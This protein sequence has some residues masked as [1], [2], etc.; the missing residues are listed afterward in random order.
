MLGTYNEVVIEMNNQTSTNDSTDR[1]ESLQQQINPVQQNHNDMNVP[2]SN[3]PILSNIVES[4]PARSPSPFLLCIDENT[5]VPS[6][7]AISSAVTTKTTTLT[8]DSLLAK[9]STTT[10]D[11]I[12][13]QNNLI[14]TDSSITI[15]RSSLSSAE[16]PSLTKTIQNNRAASRILAPSTTIKRM[17]ASSE[18]IKEIKLLQ[19]TVN[20]RDAE[21]KKLKDQNEQLKNELEKMSKC[22][23]SM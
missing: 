7:S 19:S 20:L 14:N 4:I 1:P 11:E 22:S 18:A 3:S 12:P 23:M 9:Y 6:P 8:S 15:Q 17:M 21:I 13:L 2:V 10:S 16:S 5:S